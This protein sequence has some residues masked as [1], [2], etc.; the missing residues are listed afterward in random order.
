MEKGRE[1]SLTTE[2]RR[3]IEGKNFSGRVIGMIHSRRRSGETPMVF[4]GP[5]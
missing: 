3:K 5:S 2:S 4:S 1:A